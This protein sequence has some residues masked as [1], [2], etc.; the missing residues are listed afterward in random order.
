MGQ[1]RLT[2]SAL[3]RTAEQFHILVDSV[4][5]YAIYLLEPT[6]NIVTWNTGAEKIKQYTAEEIIGQISPAFI[7]QDNPRN[8]AKKA[9]EPVRTR[10][11]PDISRSHCGFWSL[12]IIG[13]RAIRCPAC[14]LISAMKF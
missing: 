3:R 1:D 8:R 13:V 10:A 4:E 5:E 11:L 9:E 14:L 2:K 6:G 12:K 7:L